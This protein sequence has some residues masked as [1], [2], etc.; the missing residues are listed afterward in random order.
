MLVVRRGE[1]GDLEAVAAI[2]QASLGAAQW[3][4]ADYLQ[5]DFRV[6]IEAGR[7]CAFLVARR[8][9]P[10]EYELLN[11][12]AQPEFRRKGVATQLVKA[13]LNETSGTV[14]LEVRESNRAAR[15]FYK[16]LK[17]EEVS[18][19]PNYYDNPPESAIVMKFHSC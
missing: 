2:Q 4:P 18:A 14:Y 12:A 6:A 17:F 7:V 5:H 11:L 1:P 19:R 13:F 3:P 15:E 9:A 10:G 16:G 8:V